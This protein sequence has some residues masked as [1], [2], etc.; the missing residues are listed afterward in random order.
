MDYDA[1]FFNKTQQNPYII[2]V[3]QKVINNPVNLIND[4]KR[5]INMIHYL[6][7][8]FINQLYITIFILLKYPV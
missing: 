4:I 8:N 5:E 7:K 2:F 6:V 1:S 3:T